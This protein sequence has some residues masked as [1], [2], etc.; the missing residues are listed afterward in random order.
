MINR[1][2]MLLAVAVGAMA[3]AQNVYVW[4]QQQPYRQQ[5]GPTRPTVPRATSFYAPAHNYY[6]NNWMSGG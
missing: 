4:Q 6:R 3:A 1:I 5:P 2:A